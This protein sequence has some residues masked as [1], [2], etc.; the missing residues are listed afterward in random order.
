MGN[1]ADNTNK[2]N[3]LDEMKEFFERYRLPTLNGGSKLNG[4]DASLINSVK[5]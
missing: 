2:F 5:Q 3:N 4:L 1:I